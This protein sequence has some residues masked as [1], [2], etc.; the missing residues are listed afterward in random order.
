[1]KHLEVSGT[2]RPLY[3]SLGVKGLS[4]HV[5]SYMFRSCKVIIISDIKMFHGALSVNIHKTLDPVCLR[6]TF[7]TLNAKKHARAHARTRVR[8]CMYTHS[9]AACFLFLYKKFIIA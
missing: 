2:V 7:H 8:V 6:F 4:D 1:M 9:I 5:R 3:G